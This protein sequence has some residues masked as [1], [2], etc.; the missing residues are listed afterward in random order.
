MRV[1]AKE[2]RSKK[3]TFNSVVP[4]YTKTDPWKVVLGKLIFFRKNYFQKYRSSGTW[5]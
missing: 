3:I 2:M 4:G 5:C 1:Y